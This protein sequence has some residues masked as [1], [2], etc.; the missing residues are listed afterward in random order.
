MN[1]DTTELIRLVEPFVPF[2]KREKFDALAREL[3]RQ[4][5][6]HDGPAFPVP[7]VH[8][9]NGQ[10]QFG[11]AGMSL[12]DWFAGQDA[13]AEW[14]FP[15]AVIPKSMAEALAGRPQPSFWGYCKSPEEYL[16]ALTW[17]ADWR[18]ALKYLRADAMLRARQKG[19]R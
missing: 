11:S 12:R 6:P 18:A 4:P 3:A 5:A 8:C 19:T 7:D 17:E 15:D 2:E 10:I 1:P 16:S 14:D 9:P 13:L